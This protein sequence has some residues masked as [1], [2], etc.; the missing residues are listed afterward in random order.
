ML[1]A[2]AA[3]YPQ[4]RA[5][6]THHYYVLELQ[7]DVPGCATPVQPAH[8]AAALGAEL[9][10]QAGELQDHWL[11]RHEK[12][13]PLSR[14][15]VHSETPPEADLVLQRWKLLKRVA[16]G[17]APSHTKRCVG[18]TCVSER[19]IARALQDV[20]RQQVRQ[21]HKRNVIYDPAKMRHLYPE[22][23]PPAA[24][25]A[26]MQPRAPIP[27]QAE[28]SVN[29]T[30]VFAQQFKIADPLF[31]EQWHLINSKRPTHDLNMTGA[32]QLASG[33]GVTVSLI[34]DG[35]DMTHPDLISKFNAKASYDFNEH[36][37]LPEPRLADDL[38]GTRCAGEIAAE[39][40]SHCGVGVAPDAHVAGVRILSGPISDVDEAAALNYGYQDSSV[41]SCSWG[42]PDDG[43]SMDAPKGLVAK[44]MLNG[45]Y[46][47]RGGAGSI[48]VFA[49][50]NGGA[51]DDQC[52]FDGY[53]NSIYTVT[54]AAID[55][56]GRHP[57]YSEM[58]SAILASSWSSGGDQNIYTTDV[59]SKSSRECT[60]RHGGT[61]AAAPL[62]AGIIALGLEVR[63]E[64]TWRDVQALVIQSAVPLSE[65]DPD[66]QR[67]QAGRM[68]NHKFGFG[69]VDATRFVT[70]AKQHKLLPPQAWLELPPVK[71]GAK[72][73]NFK[74]GAPRNASISVTRNAMRRANL[75]GIEHVTV[76]VW[77]EHPRR[78]D[79][80]VSL[81]SPH[82]TKSVLAGQRKYD[83]A[84]S[85]FPGWTFMTLKHWDEDPVGTWTIEVA[86]V[87]AQGQQGNGGN[88][89][90]WSLT[91]WGA[92]ADPKKARP[93]NFPKGSLESNLS[94]QG[95]PTT[96]V[97]HMPPAASTTMQPVRPTEHLPDN[98]HVHGGEN[99][100]TFGHDAN[101]PPASADTGNLA[102]L[103]ARKPVWLGVA[104]AIALL[105]GVSLAAYFVVRHMRRHRAYEHL[106]GE[107][108]QFSLRR[109]GRPTDLPS[110][111]ARDLYDAFA[112][113][114]DESEGDEGAA[115]GE[116]DSLEPKEPDEPAETLFEEGYRD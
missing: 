88:F 93:W 83:K 68:Y 29:V 8:A 102:D 25:D 45:I 44:A 22:F 69:V 48:F 74:S 58:C 47:G 31:Y 78:G 20:E 94:L 54:I 34:D 53:T 50:G 49:G 6:D 91:L 86:D 110:L 59:T 103:A 46:N 10:E 13:E 1:D 64:L 87:P 99:D 95:A 115:S 84:D 72:Q 92:A 107:E 16:A 36:T 40:N 77:I 112:L 2:V 114:D 62:V 108:D 98:H 32:W 101:A 109:L 42:P 82:G 89:T 65:H 12:A 30:D 80:Q 106:P 70:L 28:P 37:P 116:R 96:T 60:N 4:K 61:S 38:H 55:S 43:M 3:A 85:G 9:V 39:K 15:T 81:Y 35:I 57:Y 52:N 73:I 113:E 90:S 97:L 27:T 11:V 105:A 79:V 75:A 104:L 26:P 56:Q 33:K 71:L 41:Y 21:R 23:V 14:R 17:A 63:P 18:D 7:P 67:T 76:T 51:S 5:Y 24:R 100:A 66:W 111:Q 19:C